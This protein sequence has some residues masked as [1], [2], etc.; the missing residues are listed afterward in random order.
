MLMVIV[1][2]DNRILNIVVLV[3]IDGTA[4]VLL[5]TN[6]IGT[7]VVI[8]SLVPNGRNII[9]IVITADWHYWF[10]QVNGGRAYCTINL[11]KVSNFLDVDP[12]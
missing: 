12:I 8:V 10:I 9:V 7:I 4:V 3:A 1:T 5:H 2:A 11:P 6:S